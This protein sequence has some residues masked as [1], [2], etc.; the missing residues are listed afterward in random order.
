MP[1]VP[2]LIRQTLRQL[3]DSRGMT[4]RELSWA[5]VKLGYAGVPE[6]SIEAWETR[7]GMI[8]SADAIEAMAAALSVPP[9]TFYEYPIAVEKRIARERESEKRLEAELSEEAELSDE[10]AH[11]SDTDGR[12]SDD[13]R[14]AS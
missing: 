14:T 7:L 12:V 2:A 3:R 1:T 13:P 8:P 10:R 9:D 6:S 4:R 5:T 11:G